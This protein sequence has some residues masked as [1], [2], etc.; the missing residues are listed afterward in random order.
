[1]L[2]N[3][4]LVA[5]VDCSTQ[6]TKAVV[7]D[8]ASGTVVASGRH[9]HE[10]SGEGG[11]R[12]TDPRLWW[13]ALRASL[14]RT[15][16]AGD[17]TAI[18]V[19]GQQ[20]GLVVLDEAGA[21]LRSAMLWNDTRSAGQA[22]ALRA[23][24][25]GAEVWAE[26]IGI[27][28]VASFTV[29]KWAWLRET[30]PETARRTRAVRLP[31]DYLTERLTGAGVTDRGDVSGT[32]WWST[33]TEEYAGEV[34]ALPRVSLD[35]AF[36]PRVLRAT[37][38]AG[39]VTAASAT[40]LGLPP[41]VVVGAGTGDN[42]AA[43]LGLGLEPGTP[44]I[45]LGTS[46][47]AYAVSAQRTADPSGTVAGFADAHGAFLPLAATLNCT[48]AVDRFAALLGLDR[49]DVATRAGCVVLPYLGGE[50]TPDVPLAAGSITGLR[51]GTTPQEIL[52]AAYDGAATSL[53]G[54]LEAID[55]TGAALADDA[56]LVLIGGG[57]RGA[58]WRDVIG[59]L[60]GRALEVPAEDELVAM[61]AAVQ[62]A[63]AVT[64]ED[65]VE[66]AARWRTRR[67]QIIPARSPDRERSAQIREVQRLLEAL[68]RHA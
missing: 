48:L 67:G 2:S 11:A 39:E 30:D 64:D 61:G 54:A 23:D 43:A 4:R 63:A 17:V 25:G 10:V 6:A 1:M 52:R 66:V 62:A 5:G 19:A 16:R 18:S 42:M 35:P 37:D 31:H 28:P 3:G 38:V 55:R 60:S 26:R 36:L 9:P 65:P 22:E 49:E 20:H 32:G 41:G 53:L 44:V 40:E 47:T 24:L 14:A 59:T 50:R 29:A 27:V 13:E 45:S 58:A 21:P 56:P 57:S 7:V 51:Y 12:E 34:L 33:R 15:G 68:N 8:A 46:G